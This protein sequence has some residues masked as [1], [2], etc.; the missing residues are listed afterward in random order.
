VLAIQGEDDE[1]FS[2]SQ[3]EALCAC[4]PGVV[5]TLRIPEC[6]HYPTIQARGATIAAVAEFVRS[7]LQQSDA[8]VPG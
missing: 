6:G 1:F 8:R 5:D 2:E 3:L 4:A 7:L